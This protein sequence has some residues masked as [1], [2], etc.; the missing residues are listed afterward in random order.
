MGASFS[1]GRLSIIP[2]AI[3]PGA[4]ALTRTPRRAH[5]AARSRVSLITAAFDVV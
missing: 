4:I 2:P 3:D 1:S 5:C